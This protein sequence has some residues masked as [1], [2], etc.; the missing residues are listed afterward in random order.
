[1]EF[2]NNLN[3]EKIA[4]ES[5]KNNE[6]RSVNHLNC[7]ILKENNAKCNSEETKLQNKPSKTHIDLSDFI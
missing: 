1:M 3:C 2:L 4:K 7:R 6:I 5:L